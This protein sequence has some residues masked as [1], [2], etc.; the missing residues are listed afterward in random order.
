VE[1]FNLRV[2][3]KT[4]LDSAGDGPDP[5]TLEVQG[6][7]CLDLSDLLAFLPVSGWPGQV[8]GRLCG[9][10]APA[11]ART[12]TPPP[13][14]WGSERCSNSLFPSVS[15]PSF[16]T[17]GCRLSFFPLFYTPLPESFSPL[18]EI[19]LCESDSSKNHTAIYDNPVLTPVRQE[20]FAITMKS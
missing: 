17:A 2:H 16:S 20:V 12:F 9:A 13:P 14:R 19:I 10:F 1:S 8:R 11:I 18:G 6:L 15:R 7:Q 3:S 4:T 5:Q